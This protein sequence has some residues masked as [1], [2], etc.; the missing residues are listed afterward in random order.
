M[1]V[2]ANGAQTALDF[3]DLR[4]AGR[5]IDVRGK[6]LECPEVIFIVDRG[7]D[8][9]ACE[10]EPN[11]D[12]YGESENSLA[13][14]IRELD[15]SIQKGILAEAAFSAWRQRLADAAESLNP[16]T[17]EEAESI[18]R[19][20]VPGGPL[21]TELRAERRRALKSAIPVKPLGNGEALRSLIDELRA[22][23]RY[24][25][26]GII[27]THDDLLPADL[28]SA[29]GSLGW[30]SRLRILIAAEEI[31]AIELLSSAARGLESGMTDGSG[32]VGFDD[33]F[34][35]YVDHRRHTE[36]VAALLDEVIDRLPRA[37]RN[38]ATRLIKRSFFRDAQLLLE[39]AEAYSRLVSVSDLPD[40][41]ATTWDEAAQAVA[42][43]D[44]VAIEGVPSGTAPDSDAGSK[45]VDDTA[46]LLG[47]LFAQQLPVARTLV[48]DLT[49]RHPDLDAEERVQ[50]VKRE[51]IRRL[52]NDS[53]QN[54]S[55]ESLQ[56]S[57]A[58]LAM[59]IALLRGIEPHAEAEF[60]EL[61]RRILANTA[62]IASIHA[63]V[64][65]AL[66][67]AAAGLGQLARRIQPYLV[68]YLF[69]A[70]NGAK[71]SGPGVRRDVYKHARS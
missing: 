18:G 7:D 71:P 61:G 38:T 32:S 68:E 19:L 53:R 25:A 13:A 30:V 11:I 24:G 34:G 17:S 14:L 40:D 54:D 60:Q 27:E 16:V 66:P 15:P 37:G 28:R 42:E 48:D 22:S 21:I 58:V 8:E 56:E 47:E 39:T 29:N 43:L 10:G 70:M 41:D 45:S 2:T 65:V 46:R 52:T 57:V 9:L 51:T 26:A 23:V 69:H 49:C 67:A 59:A 12:T 33:V 44:R 35:E 3:E 62:K 20:S 64:G 6:G 5:Q 63:R 36:E 50:M 1:A 4:G 31:L 55:R